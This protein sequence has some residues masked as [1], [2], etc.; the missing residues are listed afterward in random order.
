MQTPVQRFES[1][2]I[3]F[4]FFGQAI[5]IIQGSCIIFLKVF[6]MPCWGGRDGDGKKAGEGQNTYMNGDRY[7]GTWKNDVRE[8]NGTLYMASGDKFKGA[9]AN[10]AM[11]GAGVYSYAFGDRMEGGWK[12]GKRHGRFTVYC[13]N[14]DREVQWFRE[15]EP[16]GRRFFYPANSV[17]SVLDWLLCCIEQCA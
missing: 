3:I 1:V 6:C 5:T 13:A 7:D 16:H 4:K 11:H 2:P 10:D 14:G 9:W 8:G 17:L 15:G 12:E